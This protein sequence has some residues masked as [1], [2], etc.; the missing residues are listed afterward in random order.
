MPED[1]LSARW[2]HWLETKFAACG[3]LVARRPW[4]IAIASLLVTV[5]CA[6][7]FAKLQNET[8]P[9]KQWVP[10]GAEALRHKAYVDDTWP[11][12]LPW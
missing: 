7:G 2:E 4:T 3:R 8:R 12:A 6:S 5:A 9:E 10:D 1:G 11:S